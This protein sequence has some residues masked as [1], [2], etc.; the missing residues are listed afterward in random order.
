MR[1]KPQTLPYEAPEVNLIHLDTSCKLMQDSMEVPSNDGI[2][3]DIIFD[4]VEWII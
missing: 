4:P 3:P 2:I 1:K